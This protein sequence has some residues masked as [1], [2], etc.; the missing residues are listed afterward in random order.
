MSDIYYGDHKLNM[1]KQDRHKD[2]GWNHNNI[3]NKELV[4]YGSLQKLL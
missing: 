2:K 1:D 4:E 3:N